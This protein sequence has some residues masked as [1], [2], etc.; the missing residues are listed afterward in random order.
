MDNRWRCFNQN[1]RGQKQTSKNLAQKMDVG[2][3]VNKN[4]QKVDEGLPKSWFGV[5]K[6]DSLKQ[7]PIL[8]INFL[9][10]FT[11]CSI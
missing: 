10:K 8:L 5:S 11:Q 3:K 4:V 6:F 7:E 1:W 9:P 2:S